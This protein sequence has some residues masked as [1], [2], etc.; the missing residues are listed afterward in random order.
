MASLLKANM[1]MKGYENLF[2]MIK[3]QTLWILIVLHNVEDMLRLNASFLKHNLVLFN[4]FPSIK[5]LLTSKIQLYP[6]I[7]D[8]LKFKEIQI[9]PLNW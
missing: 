3:A 8:Y 6:F 9:Q 1:P 5:F 2:E 7:P 4:E